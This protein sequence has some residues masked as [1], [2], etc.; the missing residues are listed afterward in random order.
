MRRPVRT[1]TTFG[2][3][4]TRLVLSLRLATI[5]VSTNIL[6]RSAPRQESLTIDG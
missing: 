2:M 6:E 1:K 5:L 3:R 4:E